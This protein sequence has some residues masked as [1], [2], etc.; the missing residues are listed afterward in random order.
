VNLALGPNDKWG[1]GEPEEEASV[2]CRPLVRQLNRLAVAGALF[3]AILSSSAMGGTV[4]SGSDAARSA[5]SAASNA[6]SAAT[7][8]AVR[9]ARAE[10]Q[11]RLRDDRNRA[12]Q[13][14]ERKPI[15]R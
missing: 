5:A 6:A 9:D 2:K 3:G 14:R 12:G 10:A 15:A 11:W 4:A 13:R 1:R 8:S 7:Q